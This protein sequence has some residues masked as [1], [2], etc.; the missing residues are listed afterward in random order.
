MC[1][2][3]CE[4]LSDKFKELSTAAKCGVISGCVFVV[5]LIIYIAVALDGV[6][7]TEYAVI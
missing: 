5:F 6:E 1:D 7:P 4:W 2:E 3:I